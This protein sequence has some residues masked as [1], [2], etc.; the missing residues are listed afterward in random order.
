MLNDRTGKKR[1]VE[2]MLSNTQEK[3]INNL[4]LIILNNTMIPPYRMNEKY[5]KRRFIGYCKSH[6][7]LRG[8]DPQLKHT[9]TIKR[10]Q[11]FHIKKEV[12]KSFRFVE[13]SEYGGFTYIFTLNSQL[14]S[15]A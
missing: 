6:R 3:I 1:T 13:L 15:P 12:G 7:D 9:T 5:S 14:H 2:G 8:K 11:Q 4:M 10:T